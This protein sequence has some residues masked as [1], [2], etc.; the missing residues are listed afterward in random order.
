MTGRSLATEICTPPLD[1]NICGSA[2]YFIFTE[3]MA[4]WVRKTHP[5]LGDLFINGR[6]CVRI[7]R[8]QAFGDRA[9]DCTLFHF[10]NCVA[11]YGTNCKK[12]PRQDTI[13]VRELALTLIICSLNGDKCSLNGAKCF[14]IGAK[15]SPKCAKWFSNGA[16]CSQNGAKCSPNSTKIS[17]NGAKRSLNG[18]KCSLDGK[19]LGRVEAD[20][21]IG[22]SIP[23]AR[24]A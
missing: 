13:R 23:T 17:L 8:V 5:I 10:C 11:C 6:G 19:S 21:P 18:A 14:L 1:T 22:A 3:Q 7:D 15:W 9:G 2:Q 12:S 20:Q 24:S 16:K 4:A